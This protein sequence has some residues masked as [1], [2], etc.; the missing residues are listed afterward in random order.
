MNKELQ[1]IEE[2]REHSGSREPS[3]AENEHR[4]IS[5]KSGFE[6]D[7]N[8]DSISIVSLGLGFDALGWDI[9]L[10]FDKICIWTWVV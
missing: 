1:Q 6:E 7:A 5:N 3:M 2:E 9:H 4:S 8:K 10:G